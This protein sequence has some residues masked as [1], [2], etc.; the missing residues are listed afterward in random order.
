[1]KKRVGFVRPMANGPFVVLLTLLATAS[2]AGTSPEKTF[3][4]TATGCRPTES[5][6]LGPMYKPDAPVRSS[7]GEG[8]VLAGVVRSST[9]CKPI[10]GARIE[11]WLANPEGSYDDKHR[12]TVYV[13]E[14]G[15]YRFE[16]NFPPSYGGRP[17]H[18]H[19]RVTAPGYKLLVTQHYTKAGDTHATLDLVLVPDGS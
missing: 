13:K 9:D 16:S 7:V 14:S 10:S 15:E 3:E 6:Q 12:A 18:I 8:Y 1:M 2:G 4:G 5:D 19:L 11:L 17:S